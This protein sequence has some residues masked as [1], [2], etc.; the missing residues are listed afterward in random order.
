[1]QV[2]ADMAVLQAG[3][4]QQRG[5]MN[6]AT[7]DHDVPTFHYSSMTFQGSRFDADREASVHAHTFGPRLYEDP[8]SVRLCI[9][10]PR[11]RCGLLCADGTP[12][13]AI[14]ANAPLVAG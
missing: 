1:M 12:V 6:R 13:A 4:Q 2:A 5:S 10:E 9:H 8:R 3:P 14:P 7:R 11:F